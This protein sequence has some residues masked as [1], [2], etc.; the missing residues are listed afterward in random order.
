MSLMF[1]TVAAVFGFVASIIGIVVF[2]VG[3]VVPDWQTRTRA[4]IVSRPGLY[5][6]KR[7]NRAMMRAVNGTHLL[8]GGIS[9]MM[10]TLGWP[11]IILTI[12]YGGLWFKAAQLQ[13]LATQH[14]E[15][16]GRLEGGESTATQ[17]SLEVLRKGA[18]EALLYA[19]SSKVSIAIITVAGILLCLWIAAL[20]KAATAEDWTA[21][22]DMELQVRDVATLEAYFESLRKIAG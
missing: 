12:A 1:T 19:Q 9:I 10:T 21:L 14:I 5:F 20:E 6:R 22:V 15:E 13:R 2:L 16:V 17:S 18:E 8:P 3:L 4:W 11:F 7:R